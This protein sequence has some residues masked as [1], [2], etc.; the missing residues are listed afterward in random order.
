MKRKLSWLILI[1]AF[2]LFFLYGGPAGAQ[3]KPIVIGGSLPLTGV[4]AET[5]KVIQ[6]GYEFWSKKPTPKGGFLGGR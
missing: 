2:S 1:F 4:W 3:Q 5:A 6:R